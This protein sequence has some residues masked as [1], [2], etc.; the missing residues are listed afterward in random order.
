[1]AISSLA[2]GPAEP[3]RPTKGAF[4]ED[5]GGIRDFLRFRA[6][7]AG[8]HGVE[9][10]PTPPNI[11]MA[12]ATFATLSA[13]RPGRLTISSDILIQDSGKPDEI[14]PQVPQRSLETLPVDT[15]VY[16]LVAAIARPIA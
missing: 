11:A 8:Y 14:A 2:Q 12:S 3:A 9:R 10:P 5:P 6:T 4:D 1:L 7:D 16:V 13:R 15:L